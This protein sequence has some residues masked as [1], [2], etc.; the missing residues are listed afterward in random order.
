MTLTGYFLGRVVPNIESRIH[1]VV[2]VVIFVSLLPAMIALPPARNC[3]ARRSDQR[4]G[5]IGS[6]GSGRLA[7]RRRRLVATPEHQHR[8]RRARIGAGWSCRP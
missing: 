2:A 1:I 7:R 5:R 3:A 4:R 6:A 8:E